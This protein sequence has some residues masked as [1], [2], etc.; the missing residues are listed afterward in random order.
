[1]LLSWCRLLTVKLE[2]IHVT[3]I[4]PNKWISSNWHCLLP[5][6]QSYQSLYGILLYSLVV[7]RNVSSSLEITDGKVFSWSSGEESGIDLLG[8]LFSI[9]IEGSTVTRVTALTMDGFQTF[10]NPG[11]VAVFLDLPIQYHWPS[12]IWPTWS[13]NG[14]GFLIKVELSIPIW[15][16]GSI[17]WLCEPEITTHL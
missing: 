5:R 7:L 1:M 15:H 3:I 14:K 13:G 2:T 9:P 8:P 16:W 11:Q 6:W 12:V 17:G 10:D 4:F